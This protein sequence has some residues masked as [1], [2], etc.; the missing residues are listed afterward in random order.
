MPSVDAAAAPEGESWD[1]I[2][3]ED[4][5]DGTEGFEGEGEG[6]GEVEQKGRTNNGRGN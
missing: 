1:T 3:D 4:P 5:P 6:E 2:P